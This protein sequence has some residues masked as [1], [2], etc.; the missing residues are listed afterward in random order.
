MKFQRFR[1]AFG[2]PTD[3]APA[4]PS[5]DGVPDGLVPLYRELRPGPYGDGIFWIQE[6]ATL[7]RWYAPKLSGVPEAFP[8]ARTS[9]GSVYLWLD[10]EVNFVDVH[11]GRVFDVLP[12]IAQFLDEYLPS[13]EAREEDLLEGLHREA[14][15]ALGPPGQDEMFTFVP[16]LALGGVAEVENVRR[17]KLPEQIAFLAGIDD[18]DPGG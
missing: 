12:D 15:A 11:T 17:V 13:A 1:N 7:R 18:P 6:P 2:V 14:V 4:I 5:G 16:A 8:F 3:E 9:F 10:R